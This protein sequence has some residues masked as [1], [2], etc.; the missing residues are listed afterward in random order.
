MSCK[1]EKREERMVSIRNCRAWMGWVWVWEIR[2]EN[3]SL[4]N[5]VMF[6]ERENE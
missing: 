5:R 1:T 6:L 4:M 3:P 2:G